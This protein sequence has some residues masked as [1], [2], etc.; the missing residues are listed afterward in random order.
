MRLADYYECTACTACVDRCGHNALT[1]FI[2]KN[3]YYAIKAD[4]QRCVDCG[5]CSKV[6]PVIRDNKENEKRQVSNDSFACWSLDS[7][8]RKVAASGGAFIAIASEV[9]TLGGVVYGAST[10]GFRVRHIRVCDQSDLYRVAGSKYQ[11]SEMIGVYRQIQKDLKKGKIV[12]FGGL[13]CQV[14][15]LK[16][17]INHDLARRLFTIDTICGGISTMAPMMAI[18]NEAKYK[19]I[20]SFRDK[21]NGW[22]SENFEYSLK[23]YKYDGTIED[24]GPHHIVLKSFCN[25]ILKRSSCLDCKFNGFQRVSDCTIGD[26]WGDEQFPEEHKNGLSVLIKHSERLDEII[27]TSTLHLEPTSLEH[28]IRHNNNYFWTHY[29]FIRKSRLRKKILRALEKRDISLAES[30]MEHISLYDRIFL[31][32]HYWLNSKNKQ[33]YYNCHIHKK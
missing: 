23:L 16:L 28:I 15:A 1:S 32:F 33:D 22:K 17:Y 26:Y 25:P 2:D 11:Q 19:G 12:L 29:P 21:E 7:R 3:G 8:L 20:C 18:Q 10:D 30:I 9:L 14:A 6:C 27:E 31:K 24:L 5:A 4:A 13:S